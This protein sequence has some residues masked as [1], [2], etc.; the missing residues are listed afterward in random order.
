MIEYI[1]ETAF[2]TLM[3]KIFIVFGGLMGCLAYMTLLERKIMAGVQ[4]RPGPNRVGPFGLLQPIADGLKFLFKEEIVPAGANITIYL[5]A[6]VLSMIP[7][8]LS[9]AVIPFGPNFQIT[10]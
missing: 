3:A 4:M 6:P 10:I 7:A 5:I 8:L 2:I 1:T 9:F